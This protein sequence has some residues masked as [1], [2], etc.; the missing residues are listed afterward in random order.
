[1]VTNYNETIIYKLYC[2]NE[3]ITDFYIGYTTN[4]KG[5]KGVHRR[6]INNQANKSYKN[7]MY[8]FIRNNGGWDNWDF[9]IL[10]NYPCNTK[11]EAILREKIW[12]NRLNPS[13]NTIKN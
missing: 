12:I 2:K 3:E 5:R 4:Y 8:S 13:L 11:K 6:C 1:M 7:R 9:I 10:E